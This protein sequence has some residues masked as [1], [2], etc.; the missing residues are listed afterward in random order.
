MSDGIMDD[1]WDCIHRDHPDMGVLLGVISDTTTN[2]EFWRR[3]ADQC[4]NWTV[5]HVWEE[6]VRLQEYGFI[7]GDAE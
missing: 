3:L 5:R 1:L 4:G 7:E 6:L 2:A